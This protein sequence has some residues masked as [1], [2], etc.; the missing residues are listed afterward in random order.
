VDFTAEENGYYKERVQHVV[1]I[2]SVDLCDL[3]RMKSAAELGLNL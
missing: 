2:K 1:A 3:L